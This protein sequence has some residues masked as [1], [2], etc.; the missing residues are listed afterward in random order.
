MGIAKWSGFDSEIAVYKTLEEIKTVD[1]KAAALAKF[2]KDTNAALDEQNKFGEYRI[3]IEAEK[4]KWLNDNY[5]KSVNAK[6]RKRAVALDATAEIP[7]AKDRKHQ[8][9]QS[10]PDKSLNELINDLPADETINAGLPAKMPV[11]EHESSNARLIYDKAE[12][13]EQAMQKIKEAGK[14]ITPTLVASE[15]R[16]YKQANKVYIKKELPEGTFEI[17]YCDPP[18]KH[19][20][21]ESASRRI[22]NHYPVM[23]LQDICNMKLPTVADNALL[24]MWSTAPHLPEAL[25]VIEKWGFEYKTNAVWDKEKI[26][27]GY[28]FR[29]QH[30]LLLLATK[31]VFN[32][33]LPANR[34][35][36]VYREKRGQHSKKP[37]YYY[38][39]IEKCF[40][41]RTK[42]ELFARQKYDDSW[43]VWGNE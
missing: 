23:E 29:G 5:P 35:S 43:E 26:G 15:I 16:K 42:V 34:T 10:E 40:S 41:D 27:M 2:L 3:K 1:N 32:T 25:K 39:W 21:E 8:V 20:I 17:I 38:Q 18:W 6:K 14:V 36:S 28:W 7:K 30:E 37:N 31:G 11:S 4:G 12:L 22:D 13:R 9:T 19:N 24:L 33:P